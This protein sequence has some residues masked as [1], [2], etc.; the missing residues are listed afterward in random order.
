MPGTWKTPGAPKPP[1][2]VPAGFG[3]NRVVMAGVQLVLQL[4][5]TVCHLLV[6]D[7]SSPFKGA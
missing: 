2:P 3:E 5:G 1:L 4:V 6:T 7:C